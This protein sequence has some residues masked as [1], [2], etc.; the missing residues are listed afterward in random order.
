MTYRKL[1]QQ[2]WLVEQDDE[3]ILLGVQDNFIIVG[4]IVTQKGSFSE[5]GPAMKSMLILANELD[6]VKIGIDDDGDLLVRTEW[7]GKSLT[8]S[9]FTE[10]VEGVVTAAKRVRARIG[11]F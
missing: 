5:S 3:K 1:N 8:R 2:G 11:A 4:I 7:K 6:F 9:E 10:M